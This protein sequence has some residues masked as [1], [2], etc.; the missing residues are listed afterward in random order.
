MAVFS[1]LS[2]TPTIFQLLSFRGMEVGQHLPQGLSKKLMIGAHSSLVIGKHLR[3]V[4][5]GARMY[6][7]MR[8]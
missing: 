6:A 3:F 2:K 5:G 1:H 8:L 4:I 7:R